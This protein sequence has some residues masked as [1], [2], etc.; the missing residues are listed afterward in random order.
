MPNMTLFYTHDL[1]GDFALMP[2]LYTFMQTL[3]HG[4]ESVLWLDLGNSCGASAWHCGITGGRSALSVLDGMGY[5][6]A[7][8]SGFLREGERDKL[9]GV[10]TMA[11]LD[12][13]HAW[14]LNAPF[15]RDEGIIFSSEPTPAHTLN[16]VVAPNP[17]TVL[18][19][20]TLF[21]QAPPTRQHIGMVSLDTDKL[22]LLDSAHHALPDNTPPHPLITSA[23]EFVEEEA[24]FYQKRL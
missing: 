10:V 6:C 21:L 2:R 16:I 5:H 12:V 7:N 24:R 8:V 18:H 4:R 22:R 23:I 3:Q 11:L 13:R 20:G 15:W 1:Q 17:Q 9:N 19:E 14:R